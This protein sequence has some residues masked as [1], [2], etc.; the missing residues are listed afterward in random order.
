M[1]KL[2]LEWKSVKQDAVFD[3]LTVLGPQFRLRIHSQLT[4]F[5][6]V[7]RCK[8]G[9]AIATRAVS[10]ENGDSRSCGCLMRESM[11]NNGKNSSIHGGYGTPLYIVW[12]SMN[13]R[14]YDKNR[15]GYKDYG[16]RGITVCDQW[17]NDFPAF[18]DWALSHGYKP[19][20]Q[21]DREKNHLGYTPEN[22]R[23]VTPKV[24]ANNRR[25]SRFFTWENE[26][27]TLPQWADDPRCVVTYAILRNR[28]RRGWPFQKSMTTPV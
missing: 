10:L 7:C 16:G 20:L 8:C 22:C 18:R 4:A 12:A 13:Q 27:K 15:D 17:R 19:G 14:C 23:F 25:N 26:A 24:N 21:V 2:R 6:C 11:V 28:I 5:F 3:R 1:L 9:N